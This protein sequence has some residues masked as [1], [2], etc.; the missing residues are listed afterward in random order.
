MFFDHS[1]L[2]GAQVPQLVAWLPARR[3]V[4]H[5]HFGEQTLLSLSTKAILTSTTMRAPLI[6]LLLGFVVGCS[7]PATVVS[8]A[9][10][11]GRLDSY[12]GALLAGKHRVT[13]DM[14]DTRFFPTPEAKQEAIALLEKSTTT[15]TYHSITNGQPFG[16][17]K[18]SNSVH[19]FVPYVSDA[20]IRGQRGTVKSYLLA[21]RYDVSTNW[22]FVDIGTKG[23][24]VL[25]RYYDHLPNE[26]PKASLE[27]KE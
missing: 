20:E 8:D 4:T 22:F 6:I 1:W 7:K 3:D 15:F 24:D 17:F 19:C 14:M 23:R 12:F 10:L 5:A 21:T 11:Q 25:A 27:K 2:S 9:G 16:H 13:I 18:G 26:L